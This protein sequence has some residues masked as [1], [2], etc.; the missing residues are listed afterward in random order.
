MDSHGTNPRKLDIIY[1]AEGIS[2]SYRQDTKKKD[3]ARTT[4]LKKVNLEVRRGEFLVIMG[5]SGSGKSTLLHLLGG[6]D[7]PDEGKIT[8]YLQQAQYTEKRKP[9]A[10]IKNRAGKL[11]KKLKIQTLFRNVKS[12]KEGNESTANKREEEETGRESKINPLEKP[13]EIMDETQRARL[14]SSHI[15]MIYQ[16]FHL[17][18]NLTAME[19]VALPMVFKDDYPNKRQ[20]RARQMLKEVG[21]SERMEHFPGQ[22]SGGEQQR[23]AIARALAMR[24]CIILADEPTGNLDTASENEILGILKNLQKKGL[25]VIVVTHNKKIAEELNGRVIIMEDGKIKS[26]SL[27]RLYP[28]RQKVGGNR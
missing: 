18:P 28:K 22:L 1:R 16:S 17:I 20:N 19:N 6:L 5:K 26:D 8:L 23:V 12:A 13:L 7:V 14:R 25:T 15:A 11:S 9:L 24:P 2:K 4:A 21:L 3:S 27:N 10:W